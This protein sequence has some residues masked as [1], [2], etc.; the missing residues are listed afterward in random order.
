MDTIFKAFELITASPNTGVMLFAAMFGLVIGVNVFPVAAAILGIA[1][2]NMIEDNF[3]SSM[4]KAD[5]DLFGFFSW[6]IA[7]TL[8]LITITLWLASVVGFIWRGRGV[9]RS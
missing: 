2:G 1:L 3:M 6:P 9:R 4:I 7:A 8:G 5:G